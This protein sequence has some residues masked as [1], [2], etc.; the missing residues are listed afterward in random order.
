MSVPEKTA[1]RLYHCGTD[2]ILLGRDMLK[3]DGITKSF[4]RGKK[5]VL[6]GV[7]F[8]AAPGECIGICGTNGSGK[9]TLLSILAGDLKADSGTISLADRIITAR[10]L[11]GLVSYVP[12]ENPLVEE[13][14]ARDNL[15]LWYDRSQIDTLFTSDSSNAGT[16]GSTP[17]NTNSHT[18]VT[19]L[20]ESVLDIL[21]IREFINVR[22]RYMSGGMKK[23]LSIACSVS[24][25][26]H[27]LLLDEPTA[28]LDLPCQE[29]IRQYILARKA[30]GDIILI[31]TH[32]EAEMN[33]CDRIMVLKDGVAAVASY[34]GDIHAF[35]S[36]LT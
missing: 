11:P 12:Q 29:K 32:E 17:D 14:T 2:I 1:L 26:G 31:A 18:G 5:Q 3:L 35:A 13:L 28:A 20:S 24:D 6:R 25:G 8:E 4:N 16:I 7:S 10:E 27:I 34:S 9:S 36:Q 30:V 23:R 22:V 15:L 21:D 33:L 19:A